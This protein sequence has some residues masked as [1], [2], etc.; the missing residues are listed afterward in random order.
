LF[1]YAHCEEV[2]CEIGQ[3]VY[4]QTVIARVGNSGKA[5]PPHLHFEV[6]DSPAITKGNELVPR[7]KTVT[8]GIGWERELGKP[9]APRLDPLE[10]LEKLGPWGT[11]EVFDLGARSIDDALAEDLHRTVETSPGGY[12]PLG[13]NNFW[14]GGVHIPMP[15]GSVLHAPFNATIVAARLAPD[16][17]SGKGEHGH[18]SFLLLKHEVSESVFEKMQRGP[19]MPP[20]PPPPPPK[21]RGPIGVGLPVK[22]PDPSTS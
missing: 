14:H 16:E 3:T 1:W 5:G 4:E 9:K 13:A 17:E 10:E 12:F 7:H 19:D 2:L 21:P 15:E 18:T 20:P 22:D 8:G 6:V 11:R